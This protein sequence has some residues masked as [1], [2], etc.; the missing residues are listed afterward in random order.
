MRLP[1]LVRVINVRF[2]MRICSIEGCGLKYYC[3][4]LCEKHYK[5]NRYQNNKEK[6]A[7]YYQDN[8]E[9]INKRHAQYYEENKE[10][11]AE[12]KA[13]YDKDHKEQKAKYRKENKEKIAEHNYNYEKERL[14]TDPLYKFKGNIRTLIRKSLQK[15]G[16]KKNTKTAQ[17]LGCSFEEAMKYI[18]YFKG[19]NTHHIIWLETATTFEEVIKLNHYT[20]LIALTKGQHN[21]IHSGKAI[22]NENREFEIII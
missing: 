15:K 14:A 4:G 2:N 5:I 8:K 7:N 6:V 3:K 13:K 19:C 10:K 21:M 22:I 9:K 18:G 20:N 11:I 17:I 1:L 12:Q 16:F